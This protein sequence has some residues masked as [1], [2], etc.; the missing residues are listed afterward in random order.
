MKYE[1]NM[2]DLLIGIPTLF[3][4]IYVFYTIYKSSDTLKP[5]GYKHSRRSWH[6]YGGS[7]GSYGGG[8]IGRGGGFGGGGGGGFGGAGATG[9]W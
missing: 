8:G 2:I 1:Y 3:V 6:G 9:G 5:H 7:G 4:L